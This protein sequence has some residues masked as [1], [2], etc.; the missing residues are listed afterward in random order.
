M[1]LRLKW[2]MKN[3]YFDVLPSNENQTRACYDKTTPSE[4]KLASGESLSQD[5]IEI[6]LEEEIEFLDKTKEFF[7][8]S[9]LNI[10]MSIL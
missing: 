1:Q 8:K 10:H 7:Q 6:K 3:D 9:E 4:Y 2:K 5:I